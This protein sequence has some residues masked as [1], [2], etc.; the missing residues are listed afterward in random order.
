MNQCHCKPN[1]YTIY[2]EKSSIITY[3]QTDKIP[4]LHHT[5]ELLLF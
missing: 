5:E 1:A 2:E 4:A 3:S